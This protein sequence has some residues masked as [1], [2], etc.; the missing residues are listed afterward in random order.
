AFS[1]KVAPF[2]ESHST[3]AKPKDRTSLT[4]TWLT[5]NLTS[6]PPSRAQNGISP[7]Y[8]QRL[9]ALFNQAREK[10]N[11]NDFQQ[12]ILAFNSDARPVPLKPD[13][14]LVAMYSAAKL[15]KSGNYGQALEAYLNLMAKKPDVR[16][17]E[18]AAF[19]LSAAYAAKNKILAHEVMKKINAAR[20]ADSQKTNFANKIESNKREWN[21]YY[22]YYQNSI[23]PKAA[24]GTKA[25][26]SRNS[27]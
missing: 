14:D 10:M 17:Y 26:G 2:D 12:L 16:P 18:T 19:E 24:A 23:Y 11:K 1:Q 22:N 3:L 9:V 13:S 21:Q 27:P 5:T 25:T 20:I 7:G 4:Y 8:E 6:N 15:E